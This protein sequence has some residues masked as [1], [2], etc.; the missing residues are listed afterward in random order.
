MQTEFSPW[1][2]IQWTDNLIPG[3]DLVSTP[4]H[5]GI[6]VTAEAAML[7]SPAARKCG[8]RDGGCLWFE[9]DCQEHVVLRELL[10][11]G[12]WSIP[13]RVKDPEKFEQDLNS[14]IKEY[15]PSYW[16]ARERARSRPKQRP[17]KPGVHR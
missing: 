6:R 8:F 13:G 15:N 3:I 14:S 7:L 12:L 16:A 9:E 5:G 17:A 2:E 1:G 10:D 11:M 4:G